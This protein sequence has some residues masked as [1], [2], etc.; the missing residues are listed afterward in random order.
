MVDARH[1]RGVIPL[2]VLRAEGLEDELVANR[3]VWR[4]EV[5][6]DEGV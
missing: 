5:V 2:V 1:P 4:C 6:R 3:R